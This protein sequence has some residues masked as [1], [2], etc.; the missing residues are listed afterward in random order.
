[1]LK[2]RKMDELTSLAEQLSQLRQTI[3][4]ARK[5]RGLEYSNNPVDKLAA[6]ELYAKNGAYNHAA[7]IA[8]DAGYMDKVLQYALYGLRSGD[9]N[10]TLELVKASRQLG[11]PGLERIARSLDLK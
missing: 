1:M 3:T 4:F 6:A 7:R 8:Y 10:C 9:K 2:V 5:V 11:N